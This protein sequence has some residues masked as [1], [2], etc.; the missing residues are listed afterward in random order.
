MM[1][2]EQVRG[3]A[4]DRTNFLN[5]TRCE[6][7]AA[8]DDPGPKSRAKIGDARCTFRQSRGT[9]P[10]QA[11][12]ARSLTRARTQEMIN[13]G[14]ATCLNGDVRGADRLGHGEQYSRGF[15]QGV[16]GLT[17]SRTER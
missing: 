5:P 3:E 15:S 12:S 1:V 10:D 11:A 13:T 14:L 7:R 4:E 9:F 17:V 2:M 6:D 8:S 16:R